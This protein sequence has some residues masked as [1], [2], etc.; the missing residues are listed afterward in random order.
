MTTSSELKTT[1]DGSKKSKPS[2]G[3]VLLGI[4]PGA[5]LIIL[6][7]KVCF[8]MVAVNSAEDPV[9][10]LQNRPLARACMWVSDNLKPSWA[11]EMQKPLKHPALPKKDD[12]Q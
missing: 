2:M 3:I 5:L 1:D 10:E 12:G 7:V 4:L 11:K 6:G 9:T 8:D